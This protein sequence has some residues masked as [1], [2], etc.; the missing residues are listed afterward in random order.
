MGAPSSLLGNARA[1]ARDFPRDRMPPGYLW[2]VVDYVPTVIDANLSSR[3][4]WIWGS[5]AMTGDAETG[6]YAPYL[7]GDKLLVQT[8]N[9]RLFEVLPDSPYTVT[10]RGAL[11]RARQNPILFVDTVVHFDTARAM[12]PRLITNVGGTPTI[13]AANGAH[14]FSPVG[15]VYKSRLV[16]GGAPGE[17]NRVRFS[18]VNQLL[19]AAASY[20]NLSFIDTDLPV[21]ALAA[22]RAVILVF[23][24]GS[25]GRIRGATP[26]SSP[27][28]DGDMNPEPL[29][30]RAGCSE[31]RTIAYWNDNVI[32]ADEHG[33]HVTDGA[34]I[35]NLVSQ[36]SIL[37]FW[38]M[39]YQYKLTMAACTF[40]D[41]YLITVRRT[42]GLNVTLVCDLNKRQWF[43]FSNFYALVYIASSGGGG[44]ERVWGGMAGSN[45][46]ARIGPTFFPDLTLGLTADAD[47]TPVLPVIET[48][49]Y[50]LGKE[51]RKRV[52]FGYLSYDVRTTA[53][54]TR[55]PEFE[56]EALAPPL[57]PPE[58]LATLA[59]VL[60][61][62]YVASPQDPA[63][64]SM[65]GLPPTNGYTRYRLPLGQF[66]YGVAF[67]VKQT[68]PGVVT[69]IFDLATEAQPGES[70]RI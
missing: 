31:P 17:E 9:G 35:R 43:R 22:L 63:Y 47:G 40:L 38:R 65:G 30:D 56:P 58:L 69:R 25:V 26:P 45:R 67:R 16:T 12:T 15:C 62:G 50:R 49:W 5:A 48:P 36:G 20:D 41:Y 46:L 14:K 51:G 32:F 54:V 53:T 55:Q 1:F 52:R 34:V 23:H 39:L 11:P 70:S 28:D 64:V 24:P 7:N 42:D 60:D 10:D 44:M 29:F 61:V 13:G 18:V 66:P 21:S 8:T 33:V 2:D 59:P 19:S 27:D 57:V 37:Y 3:G 6:I 4:P 68:A